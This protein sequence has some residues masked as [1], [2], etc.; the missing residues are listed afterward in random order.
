[1]RRIMKILVSIIVTM[2]FVLSLGT[3]AQAATEKGLLMYLSFDEGEGN[4][5]GDSSGNVKVY[6]FVKTKILRF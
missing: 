6:P 1:M 3:F 5:A 2:L 4:V